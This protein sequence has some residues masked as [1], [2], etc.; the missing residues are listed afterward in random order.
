MGIDYWLP[1]EYYNNYHELRRQKLKIWIPN[2]R[3]CIVDV[4]HDVC[5]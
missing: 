1:M 2:M 4:S 3:L 5:L